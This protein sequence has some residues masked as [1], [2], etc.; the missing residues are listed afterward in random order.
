MDMFDMWWNEI[1]KNFAK[2]LA[3]AS[4]ATTSKIKKGSAKSKYLVN[5]H[6]QQQKGG[7]KLP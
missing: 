1:E 6:T 3:R 4:P 7:L 2:Y 5:T